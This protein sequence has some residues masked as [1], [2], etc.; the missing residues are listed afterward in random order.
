MFVDKDYEGY[1]SQKFAIT[2]CLKFLKKN[3]SNILKYKKAIGDDFDEFG[4]CEDN[5]TIIPYLEKAM[6]QIDAMIDRFDPRQLDLF[7]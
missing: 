5:S 1:R 3:L 4:N 7:D 2:S 6:V